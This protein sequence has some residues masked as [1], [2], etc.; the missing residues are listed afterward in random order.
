MAVVFLLAACVPKSQVV[1]LAEPDGLDVVVG[2]YPHYVE[3]LRAGDPL[4]QR[5]MGWREDAERHERVLRRVARSRLDIK[6]PLE[7]NFMYAG[8]D[9]ANSAAVVRF[10]AFAADQRV[11]AGWELLLVYSLPK[12][13]LAKVYVNEVPLE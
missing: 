13:R 7:F 10:F 6:S 5:A 11:I 1:R 12:G 8:L 9:S 3:M 4:Y 2:R